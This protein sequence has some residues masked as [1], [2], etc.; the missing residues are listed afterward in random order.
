MHIF[1]Q[2]LFQFFNV[3]KKNMPRALLA[4]KLVPNILSKH[5]NTYCLFEQLDRDNF[6]LLPAYACGFLFFFLFLMMNACD[7]EYE[8]TKYYINR[9]KTVFVSAMPNYKP[10]SQNHECVTQMLVHLYM[11]FP[12]LNSLLPQVILSFSLSNLKFQHYFFPFITLSQKINHK[13]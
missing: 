10:R 4:W 6:H 1:K 9:V 13:T 5:N 7:C 2:T 3:L 11:N 8:G 12:H